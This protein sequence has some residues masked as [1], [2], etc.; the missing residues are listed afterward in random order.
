MERN[1]VQ[2][3]TM[4]NPENNNRNGMMNGWRPIFRAKLFFE[5]ENEHGGKGVDARR[6][7]QLIVHSQTVTRT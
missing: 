1:G 4:K 5:G 3:T 6:N 7:F 2:A